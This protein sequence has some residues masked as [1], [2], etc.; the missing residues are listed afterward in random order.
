MSK[1]KIAVTG[2]PSGGK[3]TLIE[4]LQKDMTGLLSV[5]PEA[6]TLIYRGGFPRK[7]S[8]LGRRHAQRAICL[9]QRELEDLAESD[10]KTD[11]IVC[12]RGSLDS[13]AY[14]PQDEADFFA[15]LVTSR[16]RELA[17]Y[18]WV[19]HLDTASQDYFDTSNPV[20][21][22]SHKEA[23]ELNERIK[24]AWTGHPQRIVITHSDEFLEKIAKAKKAIRLMIQGLPAAEI[25]KTVSVTNV[26]F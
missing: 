5:V 9:V 26:S 16:E 6:A 21:T 25:S 14:W 2:G 20:R 15:S 8:A 7:S 18:H 12:D 19:L 17:R 3:T 13:I 1:I 4:A 23:L 24:A 11:V 22:E 10:S